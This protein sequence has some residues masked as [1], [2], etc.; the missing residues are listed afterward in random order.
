MTSH[1]FPAQAQVAT[2]FD[3]TTQACVY[4]EAPEPEKLPALAG[5]PPP[6]RIDQDSPQIRQM[7]SEMLDRA[8]ASLSNASERG[9]R[10]Q[11]FMKLRSRG[12]PG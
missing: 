2:A 10:M 11:S 5:S 8:L 6:A 7:V 3:S 9:L 12:P 1:P 4:R